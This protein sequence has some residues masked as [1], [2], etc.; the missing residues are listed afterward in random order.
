MNILKNGD[1]VREVG[2]NLD[3]TTQKTED[4]NNYINVKTVK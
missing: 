2:C 3:R 1:L 4:N